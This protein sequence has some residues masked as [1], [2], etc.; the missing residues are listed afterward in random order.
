M[1]FTIGMSGFLYLAGAVVLDAGFLY[2]AVKLYRVYSDALA[3]KTFGYSIFY[4]TV[5]FAVLLVD[6]FLLLAL[7]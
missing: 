3:K 7:A 4:L 6:H 2:F 1:P 5:L